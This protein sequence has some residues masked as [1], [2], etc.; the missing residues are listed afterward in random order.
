MGIRQIL[1]SKEIMADS[2][3]TDI[4]LSEKGEKIRER[5]ISDFGEFYISDLEE[6]YS[7]YYDIAINAAAYGRIGSL[8]GL[9]SPSARRW[10]NATV[11][12][13]NIYA[14]LLDGDDYFTSLYQ[15]MSANLPED[16]IIKI[17]QD[18]NK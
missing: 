14:G 10:S 12:L 3:V 13:S 11:P 16:D 2:E 1:Y 7:L 8:Q 5:T 15:T 4:F 6:R 17:K 18:G 9:S